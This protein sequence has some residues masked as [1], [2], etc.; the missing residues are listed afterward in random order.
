MLKYTTEQLLDVR[1]N[2]KYL[3]T[4]ALG[5]LNFIAKEKEIAHN[6]IPKKTGQSKYVIDK[7]IASFLVSGL[8]KRRD[9]GSKKM[10]SL[11]E[12]GQRLLSLKGE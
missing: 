12:E 6:D 8:I 2:F 3:A 11:T 9:E 5:I 4:D 1:E 10:Y 7:C